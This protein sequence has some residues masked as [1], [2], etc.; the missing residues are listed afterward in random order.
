MANPKLRFNYKLASE[1]FID[2]LINNLKD[3]LESWKNEVENNIDYRIF[4]KNATARYTIKKEMKEIVAIL[5]ANTYTLADSY[6]TGSLMDTDNPG[7]AAYKASDNWNR[8]RIG[9][10]IYGRE[11]D[12]TDLFNRP[13]KTSGIYKDTNLEGFE[14]R[15]G[16]KIQPVSP[17]YAI[18]TANH[19]LYEQ[20]LPNAYKLTVN[21]MKWEKYFYYK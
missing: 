3:A 1:E 17:S 4:K 6:G 15:K 13:R 10:A 21:S 20:Y 12:Y 8:N 2:K 19:W 11:T 16:F 9:N 5:K 7:L 14:V 18:K